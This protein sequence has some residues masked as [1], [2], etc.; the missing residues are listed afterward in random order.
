MED[1]Y[2]PHINGEVVFYNESLVAL[3]GG[4]TRMV[5]MFQADCWNPNIIP[6]IGNK[7]GS[8]RY[9]SALTVTNK[10]N[11]DSIFVFGKSI[12]FINISL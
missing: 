4:A 1:S 6:V 11:M 12:G 5:E 3:G 2:Y 8:I 9:F 10:Q 7:N